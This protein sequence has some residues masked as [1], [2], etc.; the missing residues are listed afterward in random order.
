[1]YMYMR[2]YVS[3]QDFAVRTGVLQP[4]RDMELL[5]RGEWSR[6]DT[7]R[8]A[9]SRQLVT[10]RHRLH[11]VIMCASMAVITPQL[12]GASMLF[13]KASSFD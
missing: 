3:H 12:F 13:H 5:A 1:M 9:T 6:R 7:L 11:F 2:R 8:V 4:Q 10:I